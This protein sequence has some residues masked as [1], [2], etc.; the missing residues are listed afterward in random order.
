MCFF[1]PETNLNFSSSN[2]NSFLIITF[3]T[4]TD[5]CNLVRDLR[6]LPRLGFL[7]IS[8]LISYLSHLSYHIGI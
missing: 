4:I 1:E 8:F 6:R 2:S 7:S 3:N 5:K